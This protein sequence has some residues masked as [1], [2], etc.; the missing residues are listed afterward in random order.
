MYKTQLFQG[1]FSIKSFWQIMAVMCFVVIL[2]LG[3]ANIFLEFYAGNTFNSK[4]ISE[5]FLSEQIPLK[6]VAAKEN[7]VNGGGDIQPE[8]DFSA[9]LILSASKNSYAFRSNKNVQLMKFKLTAREDIF[10]KE[11]ALNMDQLSKAYDLKNLQLYKG[12][13][14]LQETSFF[15]G[16]GIFKDLLI[17]I[18][19][20][21]EIW[22]YVKG[23]ISEQAHVG[24]RIR[25]FFADDK[26]IKITD[27]TGGELAIKS[28]Y[29]VKGDI[30]SVIGQTLTQSP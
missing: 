29:P 6:A 10:L 23:N 28:G 4:L 7:D 16:K 19:Q 13:V 8:P 15:E 27:V 25:L 24:D 3:G 1:T 9:A 18:P 14:M 30:V 5:I 21:K 22:F 11:L 12:S 17:K 20:N 2:A 26:A